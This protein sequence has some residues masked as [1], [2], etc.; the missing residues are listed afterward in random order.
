MNN[1][2]DELSG[3]ARSC[4]RPQPVNK[5]GVRGVKA[6]VALGI[7]VSA[8]GVAGAAHSAILAYDSANLPGY[9]PQPDHN[10]SVINGGYG[11]NLWTGLNDIPL[12]TGV[13]GGT[14]M[15][16]VGVEGRQVDGNWSFGLYAY[17]TGFDISRPL[18]TPM[19]YGRFTILTRFDLAGDGP[20]LIN[21]RSANDTAAFA[22][23]ELLTF[24]IDGDVDPTQL[25]YRDAAGVH[26]LPSGEARG[27]VWQWTVNFNAL[28]GIY[29][30]SV[31]NAGGGFA[32][33]LGGFL[34]AKR[35]TVGSF[36]VR[37]SS[38]GGFQNLIF[39]SPTFSVPPK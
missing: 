2:L 19:P 24:G 22:N 33:T 36:A 25:C 9:A 13:D 35:T 18:V 38:I 28:S 4:S 21:L 5:F 29:S 26:V 27:Q 1:K 8:L 16:G 32:M 17:G 14:Y 10:W 39:D 12:G 15:S 3:M 6:L 11:Y 7:V 37:N 20:N 34:E 30:L 23:G 31:T